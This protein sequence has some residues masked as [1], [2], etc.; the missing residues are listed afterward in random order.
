MPA[1]TQP[2]AQTVITRIYPVKFATPKEMA[3]IVTDLIPGVKVV[4]GPQPKFVRDTPAGETLGVDAA[5]T[6]AVLARIQAER[7]DKSENISDQF[8]RFLVVR[9]PEAAVTEALATLALIDLPAPQVLI[10]AKIV[11]MSREA[12]SQVGVSWDF[13]PTGTSASLQ[14]GR[15]NRDTVKLN[16]TLEAAIQKNEARLLASPRLMVLYNQR[17]R[18]FV[19]DEV[20]Y[21]L[22]TVTSVNGPTLQT[23]RVNVGVELNVVATANADGTINLKINPEIGNLLQLTTL[24][25][26]VSLPRIAR[27]TVTS[28][29]RIQDGDTIVLGGL[30]TDTDI[31]TLRKVRLLGDLPVLGNLF[32]REGTDTIHSEIVVFLRATIVKDLAW[33][34][35]K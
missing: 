35:G 4:L 5:A 19:G 27:R 16:A 22:G 20:T 13:S 30:I 28:A 17:A 1:Q 31:K 10:E 12:A 11:D 7:Q 32:Q 15:L 18:I 3:Q 6:A 24:S 23:G 25:N 33:P 9:G 29:V 26:G 8:V 21:L 14:Y 2:A 34:A